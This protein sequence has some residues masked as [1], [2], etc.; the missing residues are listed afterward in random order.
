MRSMVHRQRGVVAGRK[1]EEK[2]EKT[3]M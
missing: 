2:Q 1:G 3:A